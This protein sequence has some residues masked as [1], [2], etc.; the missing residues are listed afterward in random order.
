MSSTSQQLAEYVAAISFD[1]FG[2]DVVEATNELLLDTIGCSLGAFASPPV[3][4]LRREYANHSG[5]TAATIAGT[6]ETVPVE[7]TGLINATMARYLDYNDCYMTPTG[8]CHPSDHIMALMSVAEDEGA[9]GADL[10]EAIVTAYEVQCLGMEQA[11]VRQNGF[12]Y[13][14]WGAYSS[15]AAVGKLMGLAGTDLVNAI[16]IAGASNAPLYV[17][18]RGDVSMWKGV[19]HPYVTHN[20]IQ[21]CQMVRSGMTGPG[22]VFDGEYGFREVVSDAD[23]EF[24]DVPAGDGYRITET[25]IKHF[26]AGYYIHSPV[27]GAL[28]LVEE[29]DIDH[30]E[31]DAVHVDIFD[32]A[33]ELLATPEKWD[34]DQTRETADHSVPYTVAV[35]IVDGEVTPEQYEPHRLRAPEVHELMETVTV[36]GD[37]ELTEHREEN[38]RHIPSR[39][40]ITVNGSEYRTRVD[41]P[42]GHP[43]RPLT[44]AQL[45]EKFENLCSDFLTDEQIATAID[46]SRNVHELDTVE[47]LLD[48]LVV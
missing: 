43:E 9:T 47:P 20:A 6:T 15:A 44:D 28:E 7:Y 39:T 26:A 2:D 34:T 21:A 35:A 10:V 18:R 30:E 14:T 32:H 13:V 42:R 22:A 31:V 16:G 4:S 40:S 3:K 23:L 11:P 41:A 36:E 37:G 48:S 8:A 1:D 19:A 27:T 38:P 45:E 12:D 25:G 24:G 33:K 29:H 46:R 17:S 5:N